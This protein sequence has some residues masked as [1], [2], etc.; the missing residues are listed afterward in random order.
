MKA[1]K[2]MRELTDRL[3]VYLIDGD[4]EDIAAMKWTILE[5]AKIVADKPEMDLDILDYIEAN[6]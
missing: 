1:L 4:E 6:Y 2:Y 5:V 3:E